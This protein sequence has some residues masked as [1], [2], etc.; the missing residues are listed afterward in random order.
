VLGGDVLALVSGGPAE[1]LNETVNTQP[2]MLTAS[3]ATWRAWQS[4][5]GPLPEQMAG[6]SLGEYSA[7][8]CAGAVEF[9]DALRLVA[10]R[11]EL[12]QNAVPAGQGAMAAVLGL[13]DEAVVAACASASTS[14][15]VVEAVNFNAPGQVVIAGHR[16]AVDQ[17][18]E[19]ARGAGARRAMTLPVSVPSHSSLM[20]PAGEVLAA[21]IDT[22]AFRSPQVTV[23]GAVEGTPYEDAD[24]IRERLKAQVFSPVR[25]VTTVHRLAGGG[26]TRVVECGPGKVL[27]G[28]NRRI[29][30]DLDTV[31]LVS[32]EDIETLAGELNS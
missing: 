18:I 5:G 8:V 14:E 21:S 25:W 11:A 10:E 15:L 9:A 27:T 12:M 2:A 30:R 24:D 16:E 28:L 22:T 23:I 3:V 7:L 31:A 32:A 1:A 4:A 6:H 20:R 13:D 19:A 17:A 26:A 29:D